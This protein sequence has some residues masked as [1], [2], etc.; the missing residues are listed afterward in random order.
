[1]R[2][3]HEL[4]LVG[5]GDLGFNLSHPLDANSYLIDTGEGLWMID[6]GFDGGDQV[7][8]NIEAEGLDPQDVVLLLATHYHA[9][10]IGALA[11]MRAALSPALKIATAGEVA[12][13]IRSGDEKDNAL[14]WAKSVG[15]YP[16]E[17]R[18]ES[19]AVDIELVS[20]QR[21]EAGNVSLVSIDT[22]GHCRGHLCYHV[23]SRTS[24]YLFS[25]DQVFWGGKIGLQNVADAS[26]QQY[27]ASMNKLLSY[28]F[29]ALLP[30]HGGFSLSNGRRHV[31][32]AANHFNHIGLPPNLF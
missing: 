24:S 23:K 10:H 17:F 18:L 13:Q 26:I 4:Y 9:D 29:S 14:G 7:L 31:D 22:P 6:A 11:F 16:S 30:G 32:M 1:M 20:D 19:C 8:S 28:D 12:A 25:G 2:L 27:S 3:N 5:G 21:I 15:F